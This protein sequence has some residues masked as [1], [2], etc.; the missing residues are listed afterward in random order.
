[1]ALG[2]D[3][4]L[5]FHRREFYTD[6]CPSS[7]WRERIRNGRGKKYWDLDFEWYEFID[8]QH[9]LTSLLELVDSQDRWRNS[10]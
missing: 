4:P 9:R 10:K 6:M 8:E 1:M 2:S 7:T 3:T 5:N